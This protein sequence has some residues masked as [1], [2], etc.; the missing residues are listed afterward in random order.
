[1][2]TAPTGHRAPSA[3]GSSGKAGVVLLLARLIVGGVLIYASLSKLRDPV[4]FLKAVRGY[5]LVPEQ[6]PW[7]LNAV[8]VVVPWIELLGG[9]VLVL[10]L[11]LQCSGQT[12]ALR[13]HWHVLR[14]SISLRGTATVILLMMVAFSAAI[15][16][17]TWRL[18]EV[19]G[20]PLTEIDF[21]CGCGTGSEKI[22]IKL[23]ENLGLILLTL[24]IVLSRSYRSAAPAGRAPSRGAP[25][26]RHTPAGS[27]TEARGPQSAVRPPQLNT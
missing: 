21:D 16:H 2:T 19:S 5:E 17:R 6:W 14:L 26:A 8:A 3:G 10:G 25:S 11:G 1:M 12:L 9:I 15:G 18:M 27:L 4:M 20:K 23:L 7:L 22:W 24:F 13:R